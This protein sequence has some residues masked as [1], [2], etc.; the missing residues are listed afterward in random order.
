LLSRSQ[1]LLTAGNVFA[2]VFS[3]YLYASSFAR[4]K[5]AKGAGRGART[6]AGGKLLAAGGDTGN[7]LY[8][9]FIGRELNPR[10][11][12]CSAWL[13]ARAHLLRRSHVHPLPHPLP[14]HR[15]A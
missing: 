12:R 4:A 7:A 9:F 6:G 13:H 8:D 14:Q 1:P 15:L 3:L 2:A 5:A 10:C 11:V